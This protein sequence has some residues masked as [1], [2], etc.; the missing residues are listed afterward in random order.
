NFMPVIAN[1]KVIPQHVEG[2]Y[3]ALRE[4]F[5]QIKHELEEAA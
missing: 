1:T 3:K 2:M 4:A 5:E